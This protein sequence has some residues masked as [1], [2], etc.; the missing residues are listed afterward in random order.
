MDEQNEFTNGTENVE[1]N[2]ENKETPV[3]DRKSV[4]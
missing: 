4:V 2:V 3:Q 1:K